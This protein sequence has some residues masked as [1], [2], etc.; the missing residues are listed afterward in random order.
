MRTARQTAARAL[1]NFP[2]TLAEL[3]AHPDFRHFGDTSDDWINDPERMERCHDAA[4]HGADG[5][6]HAEI[7]QDWRDYAAAAYDDA[8]RMAEEDELDELDRLEAK[9]EAELDALEAWHEQN[10]T[11]YQEIG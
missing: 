9:L 11:L 5:S 8:R 2:R 10:G 6:T 7:I 1:R 3:T 4:E